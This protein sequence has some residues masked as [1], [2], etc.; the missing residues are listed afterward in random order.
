M[1]LSG[2]A[3]GRGRKTKGNLWKGN[4]C[5]SE[6]LKEEQSILEAVQWRVTES[7][8]YHLLNIFYKC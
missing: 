1:I 2:K 5:D 7:F 6:E 3:D 8:R 4:G